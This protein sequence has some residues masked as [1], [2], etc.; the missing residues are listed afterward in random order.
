MGLTTTS[1]TLSVANGAEEKVLLPHSNNGKLKLPPRVVEPKFVTTAP[2][3]EVQK[4]TLLERFIDRAVDALSS[5]KAIFVQTAV[6]VGYMAV[7]VVGLSIAKFD[8]YPFL[9]LNFIYSL[10]S[11]YATVFVLNSNRRQDMAA[12][13]RLKEKH[14][15]DQA[16]LDRLGKIE[17]H[18]HIETLG[19]PGI[20]QR[21]AAIDIDKMLEPYQR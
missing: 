2:A 9:F 18:L 4:H 21:L 10:A 16:I 11:G 6:T 17:K 8:P 15:V 5:P 20:G 1:E 12:Q 14:E 13:E 7:N 3:Q 19:S